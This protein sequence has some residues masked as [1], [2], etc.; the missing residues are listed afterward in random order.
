MRLLPPIHAL[1]R[2]PL[3]LALALTLAMSA[4]PVPL[5]VLAHQQAVLERPLDPARPPPPAPL[6]VPNPTKSFW[7]DSA[8]DAN[9]LAK[10]GS[11]GPLTHDA[12]I[13]IIGSGITGVS[14]A[15]H[16][17]R[18]LAERDDADRT[19]PLKI[20]ILEARDFCSG[21]TGRNGGHLT[22]HAFHDFAPYAAAH[23]IPDALRAVALENRTVAHIVALLHDSG[24]DA[25]VD[26]VAGGRTHLMF[27]RAEEEATRRDYEMAKEAGVDLEGVEFLTKEQVQERYGASYAG[28]RTPGYNLWP[29]KLVTHLYRLAL[30]TG[31]DTSSSSLTLHTRT[32]VT[33]IAPSPANDSS[34]RWTLH[35]PRGPLAASYV[36]HATNAY[37]SSLLPFLQGPAGIVPT[38]GQVI[39]TR[40][41]V[42]L[43]VLTTGAFTANEGFE[44]WF[45]RPVHRTEDEEKP[46]VILGGGRETA[47]PAFELYE[48]D[49]SALDPA[50]GRALRAFLPAV[51]PGRYAPGAEP[52]MEWTGIMGFT[53]TGDPFVGPVLDP[54]DPASGVHEGQY[55]AAGYTGH[56][57]PRAYSWCVPTSLCLFLSSPSPFAYAL[58]SS[59]TREHEQWPSVSTG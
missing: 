59:C 19:T 54:A 2:L 13:A 17:A 38:R 27:T 32:P 40:A 34:R 15:Y 51:F 20:V 21:A 46:L 33:S 18:I 30:R 1:P 55:I 11:D 57:M 22:A 37:A 45:P 44:Y 26:L 48:P 16:L 28:V 49:D 35:T 14:A 39:A 50:V 47:H 41:A 56:G 6:P 29:L 23:G 4:L 52:E 36:L 42:P 9:P 24:A 7:L 43:H 31:L 53:K 10:E 25:Q 3:A 5:N 8:P 12:D 58:S